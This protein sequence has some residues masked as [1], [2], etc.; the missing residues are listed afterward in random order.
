LYNP[1]GIKNKLTTPAQIRAA[2]A[3]LNISQIA[4]AKLSGVSLPTIKRC[5]S[6]DERPRR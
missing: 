1:E 5:E 3:L 4:L 6:D 2:R